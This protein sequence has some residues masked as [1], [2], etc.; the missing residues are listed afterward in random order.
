VLKLWRI[1]IK[2]DNIYNNLEEFINSE[3]AKNE[4]SFS[5]NSPGKKE[6]SENSNT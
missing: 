6:K 4:I 3:G 5:A 1:L 2:N